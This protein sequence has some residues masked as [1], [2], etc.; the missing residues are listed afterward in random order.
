MGVREGEVLHNRGTG[1]VITG[2]VGVGE[3]VYDC[4]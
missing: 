3:G 1:E 2:A 4:Y